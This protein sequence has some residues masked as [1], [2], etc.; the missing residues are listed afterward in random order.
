MDRYDD[1]APV[2]AVLPKAPTVR[3]SETGENADT[4]D[5][6]E[7]EAA[8]NRRAVAVAA[9]DIVLVDEAFIVVKGVCLYITV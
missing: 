4:V 5:G 1:A 7:R 6:E 9:A 8:T 2:T 3:T